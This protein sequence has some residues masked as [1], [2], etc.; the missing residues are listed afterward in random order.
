MEHQWHSSISED[1]AKV[2]K[3]IADTLMSERNELQEICDYVVSSGGKRIRPAMCILSH[4]ACGGKRNN[5]ILRTAAAFEIIHDATLIHDD[6]ND[7]SEIR[8]GRKTVHKKYSVT[9][10]VVAGDF[11]FAMGFGLF[12]AADRK[13]TEM[14]VKAS[15]A[16]AES[17][18]IQKE[19]EHKPIV[20]EDDYL[21]IIRG[22]TAM[23]ISAGAGIGAY[24]AGASESVIEKISTFALEVGL[25]FQIID[26]VLDIIGDH[27][28]TGKKVGTDIA[29]GKPTLPVIY[30][31][32][33]PVNG[34][35]IKSIFKKK[36]A[37][38]DDLKEALELIRG[39]DAIER[40]RSKAKEIADNAIPYLSCLK[41]SAYKDSLIG[42]AK[43]VVSRDR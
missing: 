6:I 31:M 2:N 19:F 39:T 43:Y 20:T 35:K 26:D 23:P 8:R 38:A 12:G 32:A 37:S 1:M 21:K 25:A 27:R 15:K 14:I 40:C 36:E 34:K 29:E 9:K 33:D 7:K 41:D 10:A 42:L 24:T 4:H 22:K 13:I 28:S 3:M 18:F 30:A 16:M 5:D 17:E 11:M